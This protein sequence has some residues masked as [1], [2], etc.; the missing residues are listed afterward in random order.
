MLSCPQLSCSTH[1]NQATTRWCPVP[2]QRE[3]VARA[4]QFILHASMDMVDLAMW[5]NTATYQRVVDRHQEQLV[6]AY[7]TPGGARLLLLHEA[8]NEESIRA[9]MTEVHELYTK[10]LLNPFYTPGAPIDSRDFDMRVR[11]LAR[12]HVGYRGE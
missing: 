10:L 8:R 11:A 4:A 7:I 2:V 3:D 12:K 6:S 5:S 9:F 1:V